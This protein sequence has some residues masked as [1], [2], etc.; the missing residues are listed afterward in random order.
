MY[1]TPN[2]NG[3]SSLRVV[4][5]DKSKALM[6]DMGRVHASL[7]TL[8]VEEADESACINLYIEGAKLHKLPRNGLCQNDTTAKNLDYFM[9]FG[10][11]NYL[12]DFVKEALLRAGQS[13]SEVYAF[14][15]RQRFNVFESKAYLESDTYRIW[16]DKVEYLGKIK[17]QEG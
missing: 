16:G 9:H 6:A 3:Q 2:P 7:T 13:D 1:A 14:L 5:R 17:N 4:I 11:P 8:S 10:S 12:K 15:T